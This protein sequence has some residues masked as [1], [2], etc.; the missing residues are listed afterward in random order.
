[1]ILSMIISGSSKFS[2]AQVDTYS[3]LSAE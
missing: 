3:F 2:A 1:V